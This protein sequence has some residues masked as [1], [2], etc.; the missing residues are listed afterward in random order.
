MQ[1]PANDD[2]NRRANA[3]VG[4]STRVLG[5]IPARGGSKGLLRKNLRS[6]G[7]MPLIAHTIQAALASRLIDL[8]VVSTEDPEIAAVAASFGATV[9]DRPASLATDTVQN[10]DVVRHAIQTIG[11]DF[12]HIALLQPT[13]PL[14]SASHIDECLAPLMAGSARSVMTVTNVEHHPG[15]TLH[16]DPLGNI[17]PFTSATD[18]EARRQDLPTLHRQNGA[19]YALATAD[20][21]KENRFILSPCRA[22]LMPQACSVDIDSEF[23]LLIAENLIAS[24]NGLRR[25]SS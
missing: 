9:I 5:I 7:G 23:D 4:S 24:T 2:L 11:Q 12:S 15:K 8:V 21:L 14:R 25:T 16:L 6:L 19:V 18:M 3:S 22:S 17:S 13:S 10:N 1:T 20:F